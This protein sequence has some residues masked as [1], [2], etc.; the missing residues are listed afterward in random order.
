MKI[1]FVHNLKK[2]SAIEEAEFDTA[3]VIEEISGGIIDAG[4]EVL[5]IEMSKGGRWIDQLISSEAD[6]VFNTA[7]GFAGIGREAL[8]PTVFEQLNMKYVG[9]GPFACFLTLDK[10]LTKNVLEKKGVITPESYFI[11]DSREIDSLASELSYPVFVKPNFEGSS[12]G[13]TKRSKCDNTK[14]F[15]SYSKEVLAQF[16]EGLLVEKYIEGRDITVPY[17]FGLGNE[18]VLEPVEYS[19]I[20]TDGVTI[21]DYDLKNHNGDQ[22]GVNCPANI[23]NDVKKRLIDQMKLVVEGLGINDMARADFR[24]TTTG[25]VYFI[26][27]NA[28]P[29]LQ[30]DAGLFCAT[31]VAGKN[32]SETLGAIIE[33]AIQRQCIAG[34]SLRKSRALDLRKPNV[35]LVYNVKRKKTGEVGYEEEAEFDSEETINAIGE[36]IRSNGHNMTLIEADRNLAKNLQDNKIDVVFNIAEGLHKKSREAQ[37]PA[38]CDLLG[39]EHTGSD[40]ACLS[41]TLNKSLSTKLVL[42]E[43]LNAPRS[44]VFEVGTKNIK[45]DLRYPVILKP[46]L[47]GTSKG[48]YDN[49][50]VRND[51]EFQ[52]RITQCFDENMGAVLCEEYIVG[53][54]F[55]VGVWGNGVPSVIGISEIEFKEPMDSLPVYSFEAK[56]ESDPLDNKY[57]K[58][59]SPPDISKKLHRKLSKAAKDIF[60][61]TGCRDIARADFRVTEDEEVYF[62]EINPLPGLSPGF[63]DLSIIADKNGISY[64]QLIGKI[65]RPSIKRWRQSKNK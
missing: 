47:E 26:E 38:L 50:V 49:S 62:I 5:K 34:P 18:G 8:A 35:A 51:E 16:P 43:G 63:S 36:A 45:H 46:N 56:Q 33:S 23:D 7:E 31:S 59:Q 21:Y 1:A 57:F 54:E 15:V 24:V 40:A 12:K 52:K 20:E 19:G 3:E 27:I 44:K 13:I 28:L 25:E 17:V 6:L 61:I 65:I 41:I 60:V 30:K 14:E 32:Y 9:S 2:S 55:T 42:S 10:Y 39:I 4:H 37:V 22:V 53:R 11:S 64:N 29:S 48:I 58:L